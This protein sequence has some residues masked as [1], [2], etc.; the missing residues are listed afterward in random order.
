MITA[1]TQGPVKLLPCP[2]RRPRN[3]CK[4]ALAAPA[5]TTSAPNIID[6][7]QNIP[8]TLKGFLEDDEVNK[9]SS[10]KPYKTPPAKP[11]EASRKGKEREPPAAVSAATS[12]SDEVDTEAENDLETEESILARQVALV[13]APLQTP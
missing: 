7:A 1:Q 9:P 13:N 11:L 12:V 5:P 2:S 6:L 4:I 8:A 3:T 10:S